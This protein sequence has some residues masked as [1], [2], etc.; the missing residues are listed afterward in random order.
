MRQYDIALIGGDARIAYMA[1][2]LMEMGYQ[3]ICYGILDVDSPVACADSLKDA[4]EQSACIVEGCLQR[5]KCRMGWR[6]NFMST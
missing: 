6:R 3:V 2:C 5:R 1:P 4:V